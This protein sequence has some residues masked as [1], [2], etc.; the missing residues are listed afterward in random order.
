MIND[1][2]SILKQGQRKDAPK[3]S[4]AITLDIESIEAEMIR[5]QQE[6]EEKSSSYYTVL[7]EAQVNPESHLTRSKGR[8][9]YRG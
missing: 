5:R 3:Q 7:M 6:R 8:P 2:E 9:W 1:F 4:K